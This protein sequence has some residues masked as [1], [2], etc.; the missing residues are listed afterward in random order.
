MGW[1]SSAL[2]GPGKMGTLPRVPH[3]GDTGADCA[4]EKK[5]ASMD[6]CIRGDS[7]CNLTP[8]P[9]PGPWVPGGEL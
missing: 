2:T 1:V 6:F 4:G 5:R 8:T 3:P 7:G 9:G